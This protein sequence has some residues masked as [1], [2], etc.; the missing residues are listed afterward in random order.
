MIPGLNLSTERAEAARRA[1]EEFMDRLSRFGS[2]AK[3]FTGM[4]N[5][6]SVTRADAVAD[7]TG[8]S[9][10]WA[11]KTADQQ[12]RDV[13]QALTGIFG[14]SN[15]VEIADTVL[16]PV[17]A[18]E[19]LATTRIPN[20]PISTLKYLAKNNVYTHVTGNP[21][22]MRGVLN[23]DTAGKNGVGRM[24]A[25]RRDPQVLKLHVPMPHRFLPVWQTGP[26]TFDIP[27]IF[28]TGSVEIRRPGACYYLDGIQ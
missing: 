3:G 19:L 18:M 21:L 26:I 8:S 17:A 13:N 9:P 16:M 11:N 6:A 24:M 10:L 12:A 14:G 2:P 4:L 28:R 25:Y 15:T 23:L 1:Y 20:T 5:N 7:G 22:T 27:G